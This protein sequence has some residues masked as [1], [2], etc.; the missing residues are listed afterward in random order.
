M[1]FDLPESLSKLA[2]RYL[3]AEIVEERLP[4]GTRLNPEDIAKKLNISK[5][6]V[7]EAILFLQ[8][9][10]LVTGKPRSIFVV[11]E[12][13]LADLQEIYP[14]RA[15]LN[16]LA[17]KTILQSPS[18]AEIVEKLADHL[19]EMRLKAE[20]GDTVG[21]FHSSVEFYNFLILSCPN[22][23]LQKMWNQLSKQTLR[24]RFLVMSQ[25]GHIERSYKD[26]LRLIATMRE[27][28]IEKAMRYTKE[29]IYSALADLTV[30]LESEKEPSGE[31]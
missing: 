17:I 2:E 31:S 8:R 1:S 6:P 21:Y 7:R 22:Q 30:I 16:A 23:R 29:I 12:I 24:F 11:S 26:H 19:E 3:E 5:S 13:S 9:E 25:P 14:I 18:A 4:P 15:S 10:G 27:G 28:N 20:A